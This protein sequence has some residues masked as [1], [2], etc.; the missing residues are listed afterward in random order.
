MRTVGRAP[1]FPRDLHSR[2]GSALL[3]LLLLLVQSGIEPSH[4]CPVHDA[5]APTEQ[6]HDQHAQHGGDDA[7]DET[8]HCCTCL[9][10]CLSATT[11]GVPS[12]AIIQS[13][14]LPGRFVAGYPLTPAAP[15]AAQPR[16]LPFATTP[17]AA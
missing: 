16:L 12:S 6:T 9:G 7:Q 15:T 2:V 17:P 4:A 14:A 5:A 10:S 11:P 8:G 3:A 13:S 1:G